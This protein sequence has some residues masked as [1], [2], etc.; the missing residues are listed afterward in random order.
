MAL[1]VA[2]S[3]SA[4]GQAVQTKKLEPV[5]VTATRTPQIAGEVLSDNVVITSE[6]IAQSGQVSLVDMLQARRGIEISRNGGPGT[7]SSVFIRGT[8]NNQNIVL[9]DGVRVGSATTGGASWAAIPLSQIDHVEIV[10]GPLSSLYGADAMGGVVQIFTRKGEGKPAPAIS[11]GVG[12]YNTRNL[13]AGISGATAGERKFRYALNA[14]H[15][16]SDGFSATKAGAFGFNPDKDGYTSDNAS[17][18][19]SLE[20]AKDQEIGLSL[21]HNHLNAQ[22]DNS[23]IFD[24]RNVQTLDTI[25]LHA[26]NRITSSWLS[27]VQLS[28]SDDKLASI[29]ASGRN[30]F[31]TRQTGLSWQNDVSIGKDV[32]QMVL[33]RRE[34]KAD[35]SN[36][37]VNRTRTTN[38]VA[39]AYQLRRGAHLATASVRNDDSSQTGATTTGSLAYGYRMTNALRANASLGTSFRAPTFNE[40]FFPG[41]GIA[42]NR[43]EKGRNMEAGLYHDDGKSQFSA[44]YYHNRITDLLVT[45]FPCPVDPATHQFGCAY[46]VN[47][48]LLSGVTFGASTTLGNYLMHGSLDLQDPHD[49]TTGRQLARRARHHGTVGVDYHAGSVRA[50]SELVFAS[51]R[52]DDAANRNVLGGYTL[53][54]LH[55]SYD[56]APDWSLFGRW[57]NVFDKKYELVRNY[58]TAG[59]SLFIGVRY[60]MK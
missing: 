46:N 36:A 29:T 33:E 39:A 30:F 11:A 58:A 22:F 52:Y 28:Q 50:G 38:S 57:D 51:R 19:F 45:A 4:F 49:E 31:D 54:N 13:E 59:S 23:R 2:A 44:V 37:A 32:L 9:V 53:V 6:E 34:E 60:A 18:Q 17:G 27:T 12:S 14:A 47:K 20:L 8:A 10:Y 3:T 24:D 25:A 21:L 42:S 56:F 48:A 1:A 35:T 26:K 55:A 15:E 5:V 7:N 40:L 16:T 43:P 41:Y